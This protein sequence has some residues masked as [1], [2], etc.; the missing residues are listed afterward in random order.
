MTSTPGD[1]RCL[2]AVLIEPQLAHFRQLCGLEGVPLTTS[3]EGWHRHAVLAPDRVFLFARDRSRVPGLRHEATVLQAL[4]GRG[5]PAARLLGQWDDRAVSP[6]PF[7]AVSR[8][9][10][11][12]W[13]QREGGVALEQVERMLDGL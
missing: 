10:G 8:L 11:Q 6:Y 13:S 12:T 3:F 1:D 9:P 5:V 7:L 4:D 2:R